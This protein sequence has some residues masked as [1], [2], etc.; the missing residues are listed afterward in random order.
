MTTAR[1]VNRINTDFWSRVSYSA[2][3]QPHVKAALPVMT[4][5]PRA[6]HVTGI[7]TTKEHRRQ[8]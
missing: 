6:W 5:D 4:E 8:P 2:D 7:A 3:A 1:D